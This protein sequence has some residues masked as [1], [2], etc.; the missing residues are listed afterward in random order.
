MQP[1]GGNV[2]SPG[3]LLHCVSATVNLTVTTPVWFP[4]LV[5]TTVRLL[6][7]PAKVNVICG[8]RAGFVLA[9]TAA[10]TDRAFGAV[11]MA[12]SLS[13]SLKVNGPSGAVLLPFL[14]VW[15]GMLATITGLLLLKATIVTMLEMS[16]S[17]AT[18]GPPSPG[19]L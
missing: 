6:P 12:L 11:P 16:L 2:L 3:L 4:V 8:V 17:T 7:V 18:G 5:T 10:E 1:V 13:E 9:I 14:S 19:T 15:A